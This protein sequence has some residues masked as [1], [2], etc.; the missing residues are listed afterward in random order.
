VVLNKLYKI[1]TQDNIHTCLVEPMEEEGPSIVVIPLFADNEDTSSD[2]G[3]EAAAAA[4]RRAPTCVVQHDVMANVDEI[5]FSEILPDVFQSRYRMKMPVIMKNMAGQWPALLRWGEPDVL[6]DS[7]V[8]LEG[9]TLVSKDNLNFL[10]HE[11]CDQ[12]SIP[13]KDAVL[14]ILSDS[15]LDTGDTKMYCRLYGD[16]HPELLLD[17]DST[18][19]CALASHGEEIIEGIEN[20]FSFIPKNVG[21]WVSSR[22]CITPLHY[23][24]CHGFLCQVVG[25]KQF[26]LAPPTDTQ[27]L[28]RNTSIATKNQ[29]SSRV[30]LHK[31][32]EHDADER[33]KYPN[34][35]E[36]QL[37]CANLSP[38]DVLYTPPGWW[39]AVTSVDTSISILL[40]FDMT[41]TEHLSILQSL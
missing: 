40:P 17:I 4:V 28:Y 18:S 37:F 27:Y 8:S 1:R 22:G 10:L 31:W 9:T 6:T 5:D 35:D 15:S 33:G 3:E 34:V 36:A 32:L 7:M 25:R 24:L 13:V 16:A 21:V 38:G 12:K 11:L 41:G 14:E 26:L 30:N 23:D 39:H 20:V 2:E 29:T 19:L